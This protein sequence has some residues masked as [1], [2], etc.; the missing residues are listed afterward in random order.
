MKK[1]L[2][3]VSAVMMLSVSAFAGVNE[4]VSSLEATVATLTERVAAL[5]SRSSGGASATWSCSARCGGYTE[6]GVLE[7]RPVSADGRTS[8]HALRRMQ[9]SCHD[10]NVF[11]GVNSDSNHSLI[12]ATVSNAC[13][14]N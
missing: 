3:I 10:S 1:I 9:N 7:S 5:E 8:G 6:A 14:R 12:M 11:I 4:R 2:M 13:V